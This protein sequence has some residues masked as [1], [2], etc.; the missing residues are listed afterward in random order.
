MNDP[1]RLQTDRRLLEK[2][3]LKKARIQSVILGTA[4][5]IAIIFMIY[6]FT[7][8]IEADRGRMEL[9]KMTEI[10]DAEIA[11]LQG[12]LKECEDGKK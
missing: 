12:K 6:G 4:G 5:I 10:K 8:S 11:T 2:E 1:E 3:M 9:E 7:Q